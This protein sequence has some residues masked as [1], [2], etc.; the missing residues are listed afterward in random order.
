MS[1]VREASKMLSRT[2]P[3][4]PVPVSENSERVQDELE[5][6]LMSTFGGSY[7]SRGASVAAIIPEELP[8]SRQILSHR[9][10][11]WTIWTLVLLNTLQMG[12]E[13]DHPDQTHVWLACENFFTLAF[14]L[15]M[16]LKLWAL[17]ADYFKD[18]GNLLDGFIV[19]L[20]IIDVWILSVV[21]E[22]M[23]LQSL[24]ILRL[25]RLVRVVKILKQWRKVVLLL[26]G[27]LA[28]MQASLFVGTLLG[29]SIYCCAVFCV[30]FIGKQTEY[31]GY[32]EDPVEINQQEVMANF[33]PHL[34][35]GSMGRAMLTL[36]SI[37]IFAEWTEIVRPVYLKQPGLVVFF[38]A[39]ALFVCFGVLNV[40]IGMI[41]DSVTDYSYRF[42]AAEEERVRKVRQDKVKKIIRF[43]DSEYPGLHQGLESEEV[44]QCIRNET[45][46]EVFEGMNLPAG[47]TGREMMNLLD[48]DGSGVLYRGQFARNLLRLADGGQFQQSCML[49]S[50]LNELKKQVRESTLRL[51]VRLKEIEKR[52]STGSEACED[53]RIYEKREPKELREGRSEHMSN[54]GWGAL[55]PQ[56]LP[57]GVDGDASPHSASQER[58]LQKAQAVAGLP[59]PSQGSTKT[60]TFAAEVRE[61]CGIL[62]TDAAAK[63]LQAISIE[64]AEA[65]KRAW[66]L[67]V[68]VQKDSSLSIP[69]GSPVKPMEQASMLQ[70]VPPKP[71]SLSADQAISRRLPPLDRRAL[72]PPSAAAAAAAVQSAG[73]EARLLPTTILSAEGRLSNLD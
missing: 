21:G 9:F 62:A 69:A 70:S 56:M 23:D 28:A 20:A 14:F 27:L 10:F 7:P 8:L 17:R 11:Q 58:K 13:A 57:C 24:S 48:S 2:A 39:F 31:P 68:S 15:E 73:P 67:H 63:Q 12:I 60:V 26:H 22:D 36:F 72:Q 35:F 6:E 30:G 47:L 1:L 51:E 46:K 59:A 65:L 40:I 41:V 71:Q 61:Q 42:E 33:N 55:L 43:L 29:L 44:A 49:Q 45:M 53:P 19:V 66:H 54:G 4:P 16:C 18:K 5:E 32:S 52:L 3:E 50:S 37:A 34:S 38:V 25:L 64:V